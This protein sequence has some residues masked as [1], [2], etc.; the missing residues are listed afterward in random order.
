[1][2][3][4]DA[5]QTAHCLRC[6]R[7]CRVGKP[8]HPDAQLLRYTDKPEGLCVNCATT[9]FLQSVETVADGVEKHGPNC[10]LDPRIQAQFAA[11][12]AVGHADAMPDQIDWELVALNWKKPF[13]K[14]ARR[15]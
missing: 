10:L 12:M 7:L 1:M 2:T 14:K 6:G 9:Q 4:H 15:R 8:I 5:A 13:P 11:L 3:I